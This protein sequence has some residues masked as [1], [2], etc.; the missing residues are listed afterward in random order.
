MYIYDSKLISATEVMLNLISFSCIGFITSSWG[1][2]IVRL[3]V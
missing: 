3:D 2:N 1:Q